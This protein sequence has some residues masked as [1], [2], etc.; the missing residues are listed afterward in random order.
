MRAYAP[1]LCQTSASTPH[2]QQ[3]QDL[4]AF[5]SEQGLQGGEVKDEGEEL[6]E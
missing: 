2:T 5:D 3:Y 6:V 1:S 4:A